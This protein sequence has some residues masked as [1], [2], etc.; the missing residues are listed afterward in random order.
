MRMETMAT[1]FQSK[2]TKFA[3]WGLALLFGGLISLFID[4]KGIQN[5]QSQLAPETVQTES[6]PFELPGQ[7]APDWVDHITIDQVANL[8][9]NSTWVDVQYLIGKVRMFRGIM[10]LDCPAKEGGVY[11]FCFQPTPEVKEIKT[12]ENKPAPL[13][14]V[15]KFE[16]DEDYNILRNG[17]YV[18][19][20]SV[21]GQKCT[22]KKYDNNPTK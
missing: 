20:K 18:F 7:N 13:V 8:P 12:A 10:W 3:F 5:H 22:L 21:V 9:P 1:F 17:T 15:I 2:R 14:A 11:F 19:P 6:E 16:S 4:W